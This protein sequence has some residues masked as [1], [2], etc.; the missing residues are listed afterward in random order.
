MSKM[1]WMAGSCFALALTLLAWGCSGGKNAP[2]APFS[3]VTGEHPANWMQVHYS[4]YAKAPD[5]C[6][7]CHG[8]T[9]DPAL[10]G[11]ISKVSCFKCH[12]AVNHPA[13]WAA[14]SQH[15]QAAKGAL[16]VNPTAMTGFAHC[17]KC[18]G[19]DYSGGVANSSCKACHTKAPHPDKP[20][21]S[22]SHT[23]PNHIFADQTK[24]P[25]GRKCNPPGANSTVKPLTTP[26]AGT[27]PGCLNDT[28]CHS[29]TIATA[30]GLRTVTP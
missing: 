5:Q 2:A 25:A 21:R 6:R 7:S 11:G 3:P 30:A 23:L 1:K 12:T 4:E 8:S 15:G 22:V 13:G 29:T 17:A 10:A 9:S 28:M 18:H 20:W 19:A 16:S 26:P 27:A 14:L 24:P